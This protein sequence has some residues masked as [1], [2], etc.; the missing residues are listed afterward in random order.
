[1]LRVAAVAYEELAA[2]GDGLV[3]HE[4]HA[5]LGFVVR[6]VHVVTVATRVIEARGDKEDGAS[7]A[8]G[9]S[10]RAERDRI[11]MLGRTNFNLLFLLLPLLPFL[12]PV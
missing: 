8:G 5:L 6:V 11:S 12:L 10:V 4:D 7:R 3:G 1:M 2:G 9:E